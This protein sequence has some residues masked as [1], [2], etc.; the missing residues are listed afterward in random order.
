MKLV[1]NSLRFFILLYK[2]NKCRNYLFIG[3]LFIELLTL[4]D[5]IN[6]EKDKI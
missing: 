1:R 6:G 4:S 2:C 5:V 3:N